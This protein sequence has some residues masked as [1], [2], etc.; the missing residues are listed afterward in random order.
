MAKFNGFFNGKA[1]LT[2]IPEQFY[3]ELLPLIDD[4]AELKVTLFCMWALQQKEGEYKYLRYGEFVENKTLMD[5]L[6]ILHKEGDGDAVLDMAL[7]KAVARGTL[8]ST[9]ISRNDDEV[10]YY[11]INSERGRTVIDQLEAGE[12]RPTAT[13]EVEVLPPRPSIYALYEQNIGIITPKMA[14][15][16]KDAEREYTFDWIEDAIHY[17]VKRNARS[18]SF[19][20]TILENW[21]QEGRSRETVRGDSQQ[22]DGYTTGEWADIIKS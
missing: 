18:W 1:H 22:A 2:Q 20:G 10:C 16:L 17:A 14:E 9:T 21:K 13:D 19:I 6:Q 7:E 15:I 12:W 11:V 4:L 8:L 5:G 3:S